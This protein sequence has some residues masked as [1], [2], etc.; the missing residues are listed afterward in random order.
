[1]QSEICKDLQMRKELGVWLQ[2]I[3]DREIESHYLL[4]YLSKKEF[5]KQKNYKVC[6]T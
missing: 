5:M 2:R 3:L 1:M 6:I 4:G